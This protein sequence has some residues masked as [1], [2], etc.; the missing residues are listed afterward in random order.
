[1]NKLL[2]P[3]LIL[4]ALKSLTMAQRPKP[5]YDP[6]T[7]EG[8]LIQHIQQEEDPL[9]KLHY[10]EQF[11][12]QYPGNPAIAWVYDQLQP[13]YMK[14]KAWDEAMRIGDKRVALEPGNLDAAKLSLKAAESKASRD[15]ISKWADCT[16]RIASEV[17]AKGGRNA[18]DAEQTRLYAEY[19]FY[20]IAQQTED[21]ATRLKLLQ[22]LEER[23][24]K[25]PYVE[26]IPAECFVLY[27]KLNQMDKALE[28]ADKTLADD[29]DNVD[30]L[31]AVAEYHFGRDEAREKIIIHSAHVVEVLAKKARP[32]NLGEEDWEKKKSHLMGT[33]DYMGGVSSSLTA[34]YG[35]A[36]Q[37]L[38]AALPVLTGDQEATA[39]YH[40]GVANYHL[41]D[42]NPARARDALAYW[43]RCSA[44]KSNFQAQAIKNAESIR[45]EFNLP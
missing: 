36:D 32:A 10:M 42:A 41:A 4:M 13:A 7:R 45:S 5:V 33:A 2:R 31:M 11:S 40:L 9:E 18:A 17:A 12:V 22:E 14:E 23:N 16:W 15:D 27:K 3:L 29:P 38:R 44:I 21:P 25:S 8:L 26:N 6:E 1:M 34:Q 30:M 24:P 43:R 20:S 28:L 35:R 19:S 39:L 37:M